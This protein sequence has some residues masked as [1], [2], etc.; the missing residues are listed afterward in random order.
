[1]AAPCPLQL[2][3]LLPAFYFTFYQS[4]WFSLHSIRDASE[5]LIRRRAL[6][7]QD[8][9]R[10]RHHQRVRLHANE[11]THEWGQDLVVDP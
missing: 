9:V 8:G 1:V 10:N 5:K 4:F 2:I 3:T 7:H 11:R 6:I